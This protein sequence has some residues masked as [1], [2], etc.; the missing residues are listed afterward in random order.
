MKSLYIAFSLCLW[1]ATALAQDPSADRWTDSG[2]QTNIDIPGSNDG[3]VIIIKS[4][5]QSLVGFNE[6][7]RVRM[8]YS[9]NEYVSFRN[10][11][12]GN[13]TFIPAMFSYNETPG[14]SALMTIG[15][16]N[17]SNDIFSGAPILNFNA[18]RY[19]DNTLTTG[20]GPILSRPLFAWSNFTTVHMQMLANGNLGLGTTFPQ[21][22]LHT[23]GTVRFSGLPALSGTSVIMSDGTGE[24]SRYV[25]P[26]NTTI[27]TFSASVG[28]NTVPRFNGAGTLVSSQ[29]TDNG[30]GIGVGGSP[31]ANAK[32]T[33]YGT[34]SLMSDARSKTNVARVGNALAKVTALNGYYYNWK[35]QTANREVGFLAQ[36]VEQVLPEAVSENAEGTKFVNYDG[37]LPLLTEAIKEQQKVISTQS[38]LIEQLRREVDALKRK[39]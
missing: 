37:V 9:T 30:T 23:N 34:M 31:S 21:A 5:P 35:G 4:Y 12:G 1:S 20:A 7:L 29:L 33:L 13:S 18:R 15:V 38:A 8:S 11:A 32:L 24:L 6:A 17:P 26:A 25:L 3:R 10:A 28:S 14:G 22:Q 19:D 39:R 27:S 36:E 16:T 2:N